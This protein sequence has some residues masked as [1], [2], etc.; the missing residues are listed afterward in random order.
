M[1]KF[2]MGLI[3]GIA[4]ATTGSIYAEE[5]LQK[6]EAYLR[7][8]LPITLNGAAVTLESPPVMY[9]GSTYLKLRDLASLTGLL[10]N[11]NDA[12]QTVELGESEVVG[13]V[14][15]VPQVPQVT[16][17]P[18]EQSTQENLV[19]EAYKKTVPLKVQSRS[20]EVGSEQTMLEIEGFKYVPISTIS[21]Y[22]SYDPSQDP[23]PTKISIP[24][25]KEFEFYLPK[26]N[27]QG[28]STGIEWFHFSGITY[29]NLS[30]IGLTAHTEGDT[31]IIEKQ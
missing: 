4:I 5:G 14:I 29:I 19:D 11:W 30:V 27:R 8:T 23:A 24:G 31:L 9:D 10:V 18:N 12:T 26:N 28:Y 1:K 15:E 17:V 20:L 16:T 21:K 22:L 6:V 25:K 7:P 3:V 2:V 13:K